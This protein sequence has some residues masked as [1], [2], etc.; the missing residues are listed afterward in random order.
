MF[1][2]ICYTIVHHISLYRLKIAGKRGGTA[3]LTFVF[4]HSFED[5]WHVLNNT[6]TFGWHWNIFNFNRPRSLFG[7]HVLLALPFMIKKF[8]YATQDVTVAYEDKE[9]WCLKMV[10]R[11]VPYKLSKLW[12]SLA[13]H[14][15]LGGR[16]SYRRRWHVWLASSCNR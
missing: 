11:Q 16:A 8:N 5:S 6:S 13:H 12:K 2:F 15:L 1:M 10:Q 3:W 7:Y 14:Q 9:W 4:T